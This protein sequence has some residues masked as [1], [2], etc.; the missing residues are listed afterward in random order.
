MALADGRSGGDGIVRADFDFTEQVPI[1]AAIEVTGL[2]LR[3]R[4]RGV[5]RDASVV[6]RLLDSNAQVDIGMASNVSPTFDDVHYGGNGSFL[7]FAPEAVSA[8]RL[9]HVEI[10]IQTPQ[11]VTVITSVDCIQMS[12]YFFNRTAGA[13]VSSTSTLVSETTE[14]T[15]TSSASFSTAFNGKSESETETES[16]P[17]TTDV[18]IGVV[19]IAT[20]LR[21]RGA[22]PPP[23]TSGQETPVLP[24]AGGVALGILALL[25]LAFVVVFW[26]KK[27][28]KAR[29]EANV[30]D[31]DRTYGDSSFANLQ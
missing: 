30:D 8:V 18:G 13:A 22:E 10:T 6:V 5:G 1:S 17:S 29:R 31:V 16:F 9:F 19:P 2:D 7:G 12:I 23:T 3:V 28:R 25:G 24:I 15:G 11:R 4:R 20:E 26:R 14:R 21:T 27:Q